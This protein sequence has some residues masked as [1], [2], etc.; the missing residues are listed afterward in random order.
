MK[1]RNLPVIAVLVLLL[2][3]TSCSRP[4]EL[5]INAEYDDPVLTLATNV[6]IDEAL[7]AEQIAILPAL[8][9]TVKE[10][11]ESFAVIPLEPWPAGTQITL[12]VQPFSTAGV[13]LDRPYTFT[14]QT[15]PP[16]EFELV[17]VG[18]VMLDYL[19]SERL[20]RYDPAYPFAAISPVLKEGDL[21]FANLECS[22]SDRG[23]PV[24][25]TY[26]FCAGA[27]AVD[28]LV[29][30]GINVVS[31]A[32]NHILDYGICALEDT[33]EILERHDVAYAGAGRDEEHAREAAE[34]EI[35]GIKVAVLAYSAVFKFGYPAWKAGPETAGALYY[36]EREQ[37]R[38]DIENARR[39]ADVVVVSLHFGDEYTY[40]INEEQRET[41]RLAVDSGADL[42]LGHHSHTPQGIEIYRGKPI[43]Y[44]LGN[45]LFYPFSE[46]I[47]NESYILQARIGKAGVESMRL[48]PVLLGD[49]QPHLATGTEAER[50]RTLL[51]GLLDELGT[52]W[53][54]D[55]DAI[56]LDF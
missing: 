24:R 26:T 4:V 52:P 23:T 46:T 44:S 17:A 37:F 27:F 10:A 19:T 13:L 30:S 25:K 5:V 40:R 42:V 15:P 28:A 22:I 47:C 34:F 56:T 14:F 16:P 32:N 36:C 38:D 48:L 53:Q 6:S 33:M 11:G 29:S 43:V 21:V 1:K 39:R 55:G 49:S 54:T 35:N 12:A 51:T 3:L 41:G 7:L 2:L 45:F 31:L 8:S 20:R 18:D 9:V 50:L